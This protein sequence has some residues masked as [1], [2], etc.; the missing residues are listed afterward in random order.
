MASVELQDLCKTYRGAQ[1]EAVQALRHLHLSIPDHELLV[2]VGPSGSGKTS[3]LRLIAGLE[4][5]SSGSIRID[6]RLVN[7]LHPK[8]RDVALVFQSG[9]L[10]PHLTVFQNLGF[11]LRLRGVSKLEIQKRVKAVADLLDL[12]AV[13]ER[14]PAA[15]SG[16]QRQRVALGRAIIRRPGVFLLDEPLAHLDSQMR[17]QMRAELTGLHRRLSTTMIHV[18]H[19]QLE[20][21]AMGDRIAVLHEGA[22]QQ[23]AAPTTLYDQPAN[24]FVAGFFGAPPMNLFQGTLHT[25]EGRLCF[26][27]GLQAEVEERKPFQV[28][29]PKPVADR[30]LRRS[31]APLMLGIRPERVT[32]RPSGDSGQGENAV[33]A[34]VELVQALGSE[35]HVHLS[36]GRHRLI[37]KS[38]QPGPWTIQQPVLAVL[39]MDQ[40]RCFDLNS[41]RAL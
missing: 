36:T 19:D 10:F 33:P 15:L 7:H 9:A 13:L 18:T 30:L 41:G 5:I 12:S 24:I 14:A 27:E 32:L 3:T 38:A 8:D 6:G 35:W 11:A 20:A 1:N 16:G 23:V 34:T 22:L 29:L 17:A 21:M 37:V 4:E 2:L 39:E 40:A 31:E 28:T 26:R 25:L